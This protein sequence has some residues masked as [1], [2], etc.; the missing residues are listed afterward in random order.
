MGFPKLSVWRYSHSTRKILLQPLDL[1]CVSSSS[2]PS[3]LWIACFG[4]KWLAHRCELGLWSGEPRHSLI[5]PRRSPMNKAAFA[6]SPIYLLVWIILLYFTAQVEFLQRW[7]VA[8]TS[9]DAFSTVW[10]FISTLTRP[11]RS[12]LFALWFGHWY[13]V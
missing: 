6:R 10:H 8:K 4:W 12:P 5:A 3:S 13:F 2:S 9:A 11:S 1:P 7:K